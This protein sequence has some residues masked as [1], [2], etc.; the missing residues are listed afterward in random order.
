MGSDLF[1]R[2]TRG[3]AQ[4]R[5]SVGLPRA[6]KRSFRVPKVAGAKFHGGF[7]GC[8][9]AGA[10]AQQPAS[11]LREATRDRTAAPAALRKCPL[12]A[13]PKRVFLATAEPAVTT[14]TAENNPREAC[15]P[16]PARQVSLEVCAPPLRERWL[17]GVGSV[18]SV[19][20]SSEEWRGPAPETSE[21]SCA[22]H[23]NGSLRGL[24]GAGRSAR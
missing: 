4:D 23:G 9:R 7:A 11:S 17:A 13:R 15:L 3:D 2:A 5:E 20:A 22:P 8:E 18:R 16:R 10:V 19:T 12:I 14:V 24:D 6:K 21:R 1:R